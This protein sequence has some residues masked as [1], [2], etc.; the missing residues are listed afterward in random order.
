ME[1][2]VKLE[3]VNMIDPVEAPD[4]LWYVR[5]EEDRGY[6][7]QW[8]DRAHLDDC[9]GRWSRQVPWTDAVTCIAGMSDKNETVK[10]RP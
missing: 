6:L 5:P 8:T 4:V 9:S 10:T 2:P 1:W 7:G 3:V